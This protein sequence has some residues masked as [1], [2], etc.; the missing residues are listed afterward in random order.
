[1]HMKAIE[2][3][4]H[5]EI[6]ETIGSGG[7][8]IVYRAFDTVL[9]RPVAI[10]VMHE[11]LLTQKLNADR[12]MN[13]ARAA[14]RL[15]HPNIVTIYEV[16]EECCGRYIV[17]EYVEGSSLAQVLLKDGA[18]TNDQAITIT[19]QILSALAFAHKNGIQHRDIKPDNILL[20]PGFDAKILDFGIAKLNTGNGMTVAGDVLGTV[21]YMAAEQ[22]MGEPMDHRGDLYSVGVVL[23]ELLTTQLPFNGENPVA[24]LYKQLNEEPLPPSFHT[25]TVSRNLD[26]VILKALAKNSNERWEN[27]ESFS[28]A[29]AALR[30]D[31]PTPSS[32]KLE[33]IDPQLEALFSRVESDWNDDFEPSVHDSFIGRETELKK[34]VGYFKKSQSGS[35]K[36]VVLLGEAGVGKS[37]IA[38]QLEE[39]A[40]KNNAL[41]LYGACLYQEGMDAYLP[42][43]DALRKYFS[44]DLRKLPVDQQM[45][46]KSVIR[47]KVPLLMEYTERF[48]TVF[49]GSSE[50]VEEE[51]SGK[52]K[53][54]FE[55]ILVLVS[56]L[57]TMQPVVFVLDDLQWADDASLQ[58][59][60]YIARQI[61]KS[62]ILLVGISRTDRYDLLKDGKSAKI[63]D[64]LARMNREG[65]C[66]EVRISRFDREHCDQLI[67][68]SLKNTIFSE[69]FYDKIF[70]ETRGNAFFVVETLKYLIETDKI[71]FENEAWYDRRDEIHQINV[72]NRVE[73]VF[74]RR[75]QALDDEKRE[76]LQV[77]AI[78]GYKVDVSILAEI[79]EQS[80]ITL[81]KT[82]NTLNR[83]LNLLLSTEEGFQ[84]EHPMLRD[85]LYEEM[86]VA[87][88]REYHLLVAQILEKTHG[89][90]YGALIG[91]VAEHFRLAR[92]YR[93]AVP[94]LYR[95]ANRAFKLNAYREA[96]VFLENLTASLEEENLDYPEDV[97]EKDVLLKSGICYEEILRYEESLEKYTALLSL[98]K[99][100]VDFEGQLDALRRM[101]RVHEKLTNFDQALESL[102][103]CLTILE[104]HHF[105]NTLSRIYNSLG[106]IYMQK[107]EY[108]TALE[109]FHKTTEAVDHPKG[110]YDRAHA[111]TNIGIIKSISGDYKVAIE[112]YNEAIQIYDNLNEELGKARA[113]HNIG[114]AY[115]DLEQWEASIAA[116]DACNKIVDKLNDRQLR[117]LTLLNMAKSYIRQNDTQNSFDLVEKAL[118][119]FRRSGDML[120]IAECY[121]VLGLIAQKNNHT[122]KAEKYFKDSIKIN[123]Q[124]EDGEALL[125]V[126]QTF[127]DYY[128][129]LQKFDLAYKQYFK[130]LGRAEELNLPE[131]RQ[132]LQ[133]RIKEVVPHINMDVT[134]VDN[135][136]FTQKEMKETTIPH[137]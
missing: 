109:N 108:N 8:G 72:P 51:T 104:G 71:Y 125:E 41:C 48:N 92:R 26:A 61:N 29:L 1:M 102:E 15:T 121:H 91:D 127:G 46:L 80:K 77:A 79:V 136:D 96:S 47:T 19:T 12:F 16:G 33:G 97:A 10:K 45:T 43:I 100:N 116:F 11:H 87:L 34:L 99:K 90:H 68:N 66:D 38:N 76:L 134:V 32:T 107:G 4:K 74:S 24:I 36:T 113:L 50:Q 3:I 5:Y 86:P 25:K 54:L 2:N 132:K 83:E 89:P 17:M 63:V 13:E 65:V 128:N 39:Y 52:S 122:E 40:R 119:I 105:D 23:Y 103:N 85:M 42:F 58:L 55:G 94:L 35:G 137:K 123:K 28:L 49:S 88:R 84:F 101:G 69:D 20:T 129:E 124:K 73:D 57:S 106:I 31:A 44:S 56:L 135:G 37:T 60:H 64:V 81:L 30:S 95:A 62:R 27:A 111:L 117:G 22:L 120:N 6:V 82:L 114:M 59:F 78:V 7:M 9:E 93:E 118:K 18:F 70:T 98:S 53:D 67:D 115:S 112:Q 21:A 75:L 131:K 130:A 110:E 133:M 14:A 126:Y